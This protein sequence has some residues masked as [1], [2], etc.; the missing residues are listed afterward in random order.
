[1][2]ALGVPP[3][4]ISG[5]SLG[6][7]VGM[8]QPL[9]SFMEQSNAVLAHDAE[10]QLGR[11]TAPTQ[12]TFGARDVTTSTRFAAPLKNVIRNSEV[13]VFEDCAHTAIYENVAEFNEK[14]LQFLK[15]HAGRGESRTAS[16]A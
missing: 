10:A 5:L 9:L 2:Q 8:W 6:A 14:T 13:V 1:M 3:A 7:A 11:I 15:R 4:Q 12:I 16:T